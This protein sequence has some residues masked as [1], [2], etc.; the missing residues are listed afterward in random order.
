MRDQVRVRYA[1]SPTGH[2]HIGGARTALFNYLFAKKHNGAFIIRIEDTDQKRNVD[3]G[4][5]N[6]LENLR[7]MGITW[8]ESVDKDGGYGPYRSMER[9]DVYRT[10]VDRLLESGKAYPCYCTEE[11]LE[12]EREAQRAR[13]EM[14]RY[15]GRCRHLSTERKE[16]LEAEGRTASIRFHVPE[17]REYAV[18]D[19]VR[20]RVTFDSD[21]IGDFVIV[22]KDGIPTYNFAVTVDDA[23][24]DISHV[25]RGEEH[26]SNTPRQL[27]IYEALEFDR[28]RFA[29]V[30][31]ILNEQRQKLSKRDESIMQFIEQYRERGYLPEALVNFLVLL[32]WAPEG[33][34]ELFT[35]EELKS[36]FALERVSKSPAVFDTGK[37]K[38]MN[39]HYLRQAD[40]ERVTELTLPHLEAAGRIFRPVSNEM[41]SWLSELVD[42]YR[43]QMHD[44]ADI[45]ELSSLFF[46]KEVYYDA[47]AEDV[48]DGEQVADVLHTFSDRLKAVEAFNPEEI[49]Q[50]LKAT[51]KETGH[52]GKKLFMPV[53]VAVTGQMKGPDLNR[54]LYLLGREEVLRRLNACFSKIES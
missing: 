12:A 41:E 6:Q 5:E 9:L 17:Q 7:W 50:A 31:L 16:A 33:E 37:L 46:E 44:A 2:L 51:Q 13:N 3:Q 38:W 53:R 42:L 49:K 30:S 21:G 52:K 28:P 1:P 27:M 48:L 11:E 45:V 29:H 4:I 35:Q 10:Y 24:M 23:L 34:K 26:L 43:E 14:P 47:Q 8:D 32:G 18:D 39:N 19:I 54:T 40:L 36:I 22:K 25:I 15:A 20:G